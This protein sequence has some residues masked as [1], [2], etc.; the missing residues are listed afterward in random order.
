[1]PEHPTQ[2]DAVAA[3]EILA[4]LI[5]DFGWITEHDKA[6]YLAALITPV[7]QPLLDGPAPLIGISASN[8]GSGKTL[9]SEIIARLYGVPEVRGPLPSDDDETDPRPPPCHGGE[10][11][12]SVQRVR[13]C[14]VLPAT[15]AVRLAGSRAAHRT[16]CCSV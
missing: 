9:L 16:S 12:F 1:M 10:R 15:Q 5:S 6:N 8:Q 7:L 13:R 3:G 2:A 4:G 11:Q 14:W